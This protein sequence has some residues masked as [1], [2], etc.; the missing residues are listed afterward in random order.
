M[1][2]LRPT[3]WLA[4]VSVDSAAGLVI[5]PSFVC[6]PEAGGGVGSRRPAGSRVALLPARRIVACASPYPACAE[7]P[8]CPHRPAARCPAPCAALLLPALLHV[9]ML[10]GALLPARRPAGR[11]TAARTALPATPYFAPPCWL[12]PCCPHNP[13]A[14]RPATRAALLLRTAARTAL[15]C[16]AQLP[17]PP[18]CAP[19]YWPPPCPAL[20]SDTWLDDLQLYLLSDAR[21]SVSFFDHTPGASLAPP[22]T[23]DTATCSQWLTRDAV[24][25]LAVRNHLPLAKRAHYGQHKTA[26]PNTTLD[27]FVALDPTELTVDLLEKHL[28]AVETSA[29]TVGA[30]RGTPRTPFFE[31]CSPSPLA[32]SYASAAAV[33]ILGA[34]DVGAASALSAKCRSSKSGGGGNGGGG[35]GRSGGGGGGGDGGSGG[36]GGGSWGFG[37][38]GGGSGGGGGGGG[39]GSG[40]GG[41]GS[42]GSRGRATCRKFHSQ[43]RCFSCLDDAWRAEFGDEAERPR[44]LELLRSGVD[45]FALDYD[46]ILAAMYA[47]S[48]KV[49][50]DCYLCVPPD[51]SI[52]ATDLGASDSALPGIAPA[53][54]LHTFMLDS[55]AS[56]CFFRDST[57]LTP[58]PAPVPIRLGDPSGGLVLARSSTVL[59]CP[60]QPPARVASCR[61]RISCGTTTLVTPPCHAFVACTPASLF[62]VFPGLCLPSCPRLPCPAFLASRIGL[63]M[64]VA[65]TSMIHAAAP[66]FL[67]PFAVRYAAHQLNLWPRVSLPETSSTLC[68][69][70][71]VGD[72]S[73]FRV[74]GSRAFVRDTSVDK[75]SSR[76]IP[77]VFLGF[78]P[79]VSGWQF[80]HPTSRR[81]FPSQDVTFDDASQVDPLPGN[82]PVEVAIDSSAA[83]G[84]ASGGFAPGGAEPG[85]TKP[86]GAE[87]GGAESEGAE[88]GG[89][90]PQGNASTE[91]PAGASQRLFPRREPLS[92]QQLREWFAQHT[93]LRS[94]AVGAGG[95]ADGGTGA[96][97]TGVRDPGAGGADAGGTGTRDPGVEGAGAW[98]A[99]ASG[100]GAGGTLQRRQFLFRRRRRLCRHLTRSFT[101]FLRDSPLPAPSPYAEKTDSFT[102]RLPLP[103]PPASSLPVV[104]D[105][106]SDLARAVNPTVL[107]LL[108]TVVTDPSFEFAAASALVAEFVE[109][110]AAYRLDY[111][112]SLVA[113]CESYCPPSVGGECGLGTDV[114]EDGQENF[115]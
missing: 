61:T 98:G 2:G 104:L 17:A 69:T 16:A 1:L 112:T 50:G 88:S 24:A 15:L 18:C 63:V 79:D 41:G 92:P 36:R 6:R 43:H 83:R 65:R 21:D 52:E 108:A 47:L 99:G 28:L 20:A 72:A 60:A 5:V 109:F 34:E 107:R 44:W 90:E 89:A 23:A 111:A 51:P 86:E 4:V 115:E 35:G 49:E 85:G 19:P 48:A 25:R 105:P 77:C 102:Q 75:L 10:A 26:K 106:E 113:N 53:E 58:L 56:R 97:G 11:R 64:E 33:D 95:S 87:P 30:A 81:I 9:A 39:G 74:W 78:P 100:P 12:A 94:G 8:C 76:A 84:A 68:W 45:I 70:E 80:Y 93:P 67:W 59:P 96:G 103:P 3:A 7:P 38:G 32:P 46:S 29:V 40:S 55:G 71:K 14:C 22:T 42:G 57:T 62:L 13:A 91:G 82:V 73:V 101:R 31:G 27:H 37:G 110:A 114:L 54:A 66:H